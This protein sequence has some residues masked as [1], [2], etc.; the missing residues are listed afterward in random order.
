MFLVA[1]IPILEYTNYDV[2]VELVQ[3]PKTSTQQQIVQNLQI[4]MA[5]INSKYTEM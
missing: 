4:K 5:F 1:Q 3:M 2:Y